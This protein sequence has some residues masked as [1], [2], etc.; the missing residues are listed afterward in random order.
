MRFCERYGIRRHFTVPRKSQQNGR[1]ERFNRTFG[2]ISRCIRLNVELS[3]VLWVEVVNMALF[4]LKGKFLIYIERE[5]A[6]K[7]TLANTIG[8]SLFFVRESQVYIWCLR[9]VRMFVCY[10]CNLLIL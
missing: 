8:Y 3:K 1:A 4:V 7:Y 6:T 10:Y 2:E 5:V 9:L